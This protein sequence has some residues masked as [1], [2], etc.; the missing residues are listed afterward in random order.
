[1]FHPDAGSSVDEPRASEST[2]ST[3]VIQYLGRGKR[4]LGRR[5]GD[6]NGS[7]GGGR[8]G[9]RG[10]AGRSTEIS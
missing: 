4:D 8:L 6:G 9:A 10:V 2:S 3:I 1:V 7:R 5:P